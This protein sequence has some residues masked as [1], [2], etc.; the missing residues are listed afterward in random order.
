MAKMPSQVLPAA[1]PF[2]KTKIK[3]KN[4]L[5]MEKNVMKMMDK[6]KKMKDKGGK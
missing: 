1:A 2:V 4:L 3:A 6:D 5:K